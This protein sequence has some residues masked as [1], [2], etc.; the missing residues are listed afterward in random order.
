MNKNELNL[1]LQELTVAMNSITA[2]TELLNCKHR[3]GV[4]G[5]VLKALGHSDLID[6]DTY[7]TF[8]CHINGLTSSAEAY[9]R[10]QEKKREGK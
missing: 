3:V 9:C 10:E 1:M 5:G 4:A 2:A 6:V 8:M 7:N